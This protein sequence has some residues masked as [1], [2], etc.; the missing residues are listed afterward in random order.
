MIS[1]SRLWRSVLSELPSVLTAVPKPCFRWWLHTPAFLSQ[2]DITKASH[3]DL[4]WNMVSDVR[5]Y[6]RR[7]ARSLI[8]M[9][10]EGH[11]PGNLVQQLE[12]IFIRFR[13]H[14]GAIFF[15]FWVWTRHQILQL[16]LHGLLVM[17]CHQMSSR[18]IPRL[19]HLHIATSSRIAHVDQFRHSDAALLDHV[20]LSHQFNLRHNVSSNPPDPHWLMTSISN[21]V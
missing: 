16:Y 7:C 8:E 21:L 18:G 11:L 15:S 13:W 6:W 5:P 17:L 20:E 3:V 1:R 12:A 19:H 14:H 2:K 9:F 10:L 4:S